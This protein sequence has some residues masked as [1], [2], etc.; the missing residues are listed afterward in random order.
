MFLPPTLT[1][2]VGEKGEGYD[3]FKER[4]AMLVILKENLQEAQARMKQ[5]ANKHRSERSLHIGD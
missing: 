1:F 5:Q 2:E 4:V 3:W